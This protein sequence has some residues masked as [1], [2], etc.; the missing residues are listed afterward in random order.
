MEKLW[1]ADVILLI[2]CFPIKNNE[3]PTKFLLKWR[4]TIKSSPVNARIELIRVF[5]PIVISKK[6]RDS[7]WPQE[8]EVLL[9]KG[10]S[11][12]VAYFAEDPL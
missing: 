8:F 7:F 10:N 2:L 9:K 5:Q 3:K 1:K 4:K 12:R 6:E 11:T